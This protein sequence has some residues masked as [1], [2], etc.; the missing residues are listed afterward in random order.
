MA[1]HVEPD[2][3]LVRMPSLRAVKSFVAA[4]KYQNFTRA[5]EALCVTQAAISRQ[6]RELESHLGVTLFKRTGRAVELTEAGII[7]Y[8]AAHLSFVNIAQAAQRI[9]NGGEQK[10]ELVI[11][12]SPAFSAF[13]LANRL[14]RF[15]SEHPDINVNV[16]T[17]NNFLQMET[18]VRPDIFIN[19]VS[20]PKEGYHSEPLFFDLI[21]PVCSPLYLEQHPEINRLSGLLHTTLLNL[22]PYGR[23]QIAEHIDWRIWFNIQ[24]SELDFDFES[25]SHVFN[26]NDY[27]MLIQMA[28]N[29][30]GVSLGWHHLISP[31]IEQGLL[32]KV[33]SLETTF[34]EKKH[35]LTY[36]ESKQDN[37]AFCAF[38]DWLLDE[39]QK[40]QTWVG[41]SS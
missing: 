8:D 5:A 37:D 35:F 34:K 23:S 12:C 40:E 3:I 24:D 26:A 22:S 30:Q 10:H 1:K 39:A 32:V 18:G 31:M 4:A 7:F 29:H 41:L 38:K 11:C 6:I 28:L 19:K 9:R 13:W 25:E 33:G 21:Y 36:E 27:S 20:D 2:Q 17:T 15:F 14:W 16:V